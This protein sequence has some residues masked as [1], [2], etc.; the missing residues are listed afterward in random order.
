MPNLSSAG[1]ATSAR[2]VVGLHEP[3]R[4]TSGN[5]GA[6]SSQSDAFVVVVVARGT[7]GSAPAGSILV[8]P[9]RLPLADELPGRA[10]S[11]LLVVRLVGAADA[12]VASSSMVLTPFVVRNR[13][14]SAARTQ[15][16]PNVN[17]LTRLL[18]PLAFGSRLLPRRANSLA[19]C[20]IS[21]TAIQTHTINKNKSRY[22]SKSSKQNT[23][24]L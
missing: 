20:S 4:N 14:K 12:F 15:N 22:C 18:L 13:F 16:S 11:L 6:S 10:G 19:V 23:H 7:S 1:I 8:R 24:N 2:H 17:P 21:L 9:S 5:S 3:P